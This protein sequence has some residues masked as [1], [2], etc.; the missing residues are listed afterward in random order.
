MGLTGLEPVTLPMSCV[1][2]RTRGRLFTADQALKA[3]KL[4]PLIYNCI[5]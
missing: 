3:F 2:R 5:R 1:V 4:E